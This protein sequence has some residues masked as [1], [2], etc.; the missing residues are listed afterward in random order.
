VR[1]FDNW[2][3]VGYIPQNATGFDQNFPASVEE[4]VS[5][6]VCSR[7][8]FPRFLKTADRKEV[9]KALTRVGMKRF[10]KAKIGE[11]SGGQKQRVFIARAL[12]SEPRIMILDEPTTGIDAKTQGQFY[13]LLGKLNKDGI[14]IIIVSHDVGYITK[15]VGKVA[16]VNQRLVFYGTHKEF[17]SSHVVDKMLGH[18]KHVICQDPSLTK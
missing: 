11:L 15:Y 10:A 6:G 14:T 4:I 3:W 12:A 17:C 18:E 7:K 9:D 16:Y 2:G 8:T 13:E 1:K 5:L